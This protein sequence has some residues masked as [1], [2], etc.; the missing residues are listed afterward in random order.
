[1]K[2]NLCLSFLLITA[3]Q[4][5][6][7]QD[8]PTPPVDYL[9]KSK[10]QRTAAK[11]MLGAGTAM[12][13]ISILVVTDDVVGILEPG[14]KENASLADV[15]GFGGLAVAAGSIPLFIASGRNKRKA[16]NL[17]FNSQKILIPQRNNWSTLAVPSIKITIRF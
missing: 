17:S 15:L 10:K 3:I 11:V 4:C 16:M 5:F 2:K 7:Q 12:A 14:D 9:Q 1:M 13:L 6:A 8:P